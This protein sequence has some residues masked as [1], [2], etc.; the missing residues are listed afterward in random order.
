MNKLK[1]KVRQVRKLPNIF[2]K[3]KNNKENFIN[4]LPGGEND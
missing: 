1:K 4:A 3:K 2:N